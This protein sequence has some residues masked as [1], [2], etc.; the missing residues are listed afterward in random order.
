[1]G[2]VISSLSAVGVSVNEQLGQ[3]MSGSGQNVPYQ[4]RSCSSDNVK[5]F[6][7]LTMECVKLSD[8][9]SARDR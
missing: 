2:W 7:E 3:V 9:V 5:I 4:I 8:G 6:S 1:M